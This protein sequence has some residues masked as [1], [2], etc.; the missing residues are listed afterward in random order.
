[1]AAINSC[2]NSNIDSINYSQLKSE[3][4]L[5]PGEYLT[6]YNPTFLKLFIDKTN[7]KIYLT[8]YDDSNSTLKFYNINPPL[9]T[10]SIKFNFTQSV[11][12]Y[13]IFSKDSIY[14]LTENNTLILS[15]RDSL[16]YYT[17]LSNNLFSTQSST[18][19]A[20]YLF[21]FEMSNGSFFCYKFPNTP[22]KN[23]SDFQEYFK[24]HFDSELKLK[25]D[26]LVC[27]N[28]FG[29]Y[30]NVYKNNF[31]YDFNPIR[32]LTNDDKIIYSYESI[33]DLTIYDLYKKNYQIVKLSDFGFTPPPT[34]PLNKL[35][36]YG[37]IAEYLTETDRYTNFL[38]DSLNHRY[39]RI[40]S[41][42]INYANTDGTKNLWNVK[43]FNL[44]FYNDR[45]QLEKVVSFPNDKFDLRKLFFIPNGFILITLPDKNDKR[46]I[47][48]FKD[49]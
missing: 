17:L 23:E 5:L 43:P 7:N 20:N 1:M 19:S 28:N 29:E 41:K 27:E 11:E 33:S 37:F 8:K 39:I 44:L 13:F 21:P 26:Q 4:I 47:I 34:F 32:T 40:Q 10:F 2:K 48:Q 36:N 46:K 38:F 30:P 14:F 25:N 24:R 3:E 35:N 6:D 15:K 16:F 22:L 49:I 31:Y 12:D 45:F 9:D 18:L 42:K